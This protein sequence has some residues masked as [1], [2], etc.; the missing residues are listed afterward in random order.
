MVRVV[1]TRG[2]LPPLTEEQ[3]REIAA[4][5]DSPIVFDADCPEQTD[6]QLKQ[7]RRVNPRMQTA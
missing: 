6:E 4:A 3:K 7:F 5:A 2:Q 1:Y